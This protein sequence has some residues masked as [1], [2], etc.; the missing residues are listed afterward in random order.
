MARTAH[1]NEIAEMLRNMPRGWSREYRKG[2]DQLADAGGPVLPNVPTPEQAMQLVGITA[3]G[4]LSGDVPY[5]PH[6]VPK[7]VRDAAMKGIRL[8]YREGYGAWAFI[9][10]ARAIELVLADGVSERTVKRMR[11]YLRRHAVDKGAPGFGDD[12][13]PS[14]GY[15][16][17]LNWGGD[18]AVNW[19]R[20]FQPNP[21]RNPRR[22]RPVDSDETYLEGVERRERRKGKG[23][24]A[25]DTAQTVG[26]LAVAGAKLGG[27][28]IPVV[29]EV[30]MVAGAGKEAVKV[31][32]RRLKGGKGSWQSDIAKIGAGALG[33]ESFVPE[34]QPRVSKTEA[35]AKPLKKNPA[36]NVFGPKKPL[37]GPYTYRV[38]QNV[39][40][41]TLIAVYHG[42]KRIAHIDA[43]W[44]YSMRTI[45]E[46]EEEETRRVP[47]AR[48]RRLVCATDLRSLGAEG[49]YPNV[50]AVGHAFMDDDAYKGKGIGRAMYEAMM[51]EGFAVRE[52]RISG[53][54]GPLFF[55]PDECKGAGNTSAEA[56]RVWASLAR[57]YPSQGTSIRVDAPPVIGSRAKANP[58]RRNPVALA[59]LDLDALAEEFT[60][61]MANGTTAQM[62]R[63]AKK[64]GLTYVGEGESRAV[65][66][67]STDPVVIKFVFSSY[68][69]EGNQNEA[70]AWRE[71]NA[72]VRKHLVPIIAADPEGRWL[73]MERVKLMRATQYAEKDA[74][75]RLQGCGFLDFGRP[76]FSSDG[77]MLDYGQH[78][79]FRWSDECRGVSNPRR[80]RNPSE[81]R[82]HLLRLVPEEEVVSTWAAL[83]AKGKHKGHAAPDLERH[84]GK[85]P[86]WAEVAI[87]HNLYNADWNTEAAP[88]EELLS[89]D[90]LARARL[91]AARATKLPPGMAAF[92]GR[93][94]TLR[95]Y[96]SDG[97][98]RAFAAYLRGEPT[99]RFFMPLPD[100]ERFVERLGQSPAR[101]NPRPT[102]A[103]RTDPAL[104]E[105]VKREVTAGSKGGK[106]GQWSA[107]KAQLAVALY[108]QR[109]GDYWGP[110]S[111]RNALAK[112]TREDWRTRSGEPSLVTGER[113]L[114]AR[115]I[116]ALSP[117]EYAATTRAKREGMRRG[118]QFVAQPERIA[119]KTS[120]Y[121]KNPGRC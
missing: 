47:G 61:K 65:F 79:W 68:G 83:Y 99:A 35:G 97:N 69:Q 107:R 57:D 115:A 73:V 42:S 37:F 92:T 62:R 104:W 116:A 27:R 50:L 64:H 24:R 52:T 59:G 98:H 63:W 21:L 82:P 75:A 3:G 86:V 28:A 108:K 2:R 36:A 1:Y 76:N 6:K 56:Q 113:Y 34:A 101:A 43:F 105:A 33:L 10:L 93:A 117:Q 9:G 67:R 15:M 5:G 18:P 110:K 84:L 111:P 19:T 44:A 41:D 91:Y 53:Q 51:V 40:G 22:R 26:G 11:D 48:R 74:L 106:P 77:R 23:E 29:G 114:P 45:E 72:N 54:P 100:Y 87:P 17:W 39:N 32:R 109:G 118:E 7:D 12:R 71:A 8:S 103:E 120:R 60:E 38:K 25:F 16:A 13:K 102:T 112:W 70:R 66:A 55:I 80:R 49:R 88:P 119:A 78:L 58:R 4:N 81:T 31:A 121:R 94:K 30:L 96:V 90:Q 14:R 46:H 89:E 20:L 85:S 95:A